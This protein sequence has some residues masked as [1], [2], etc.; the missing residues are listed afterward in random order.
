MPEFILQKA[1][2]AEWEAL[3]SF[4]QGY[5]E[6]AFFTN[7]HSD[8]PELEEKGF[9]DLAA[10]SIEQAKTECEAFQ[11][12]NAATLEEAYAMDDA[13]G[14]G[15]YS[16]EQAGRDYW[17]TRNGHG[18]G[19]WDRGLGDIGERLSAACRYDERDMYLGDDGRVYLS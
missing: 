17:F 9:S 5:F 16:A 15:L 4:A 14:F 6:A 10:E 3:D 13:L 2:G 7:A 8:N 1:H 18:V 11:R 19:F 12:E